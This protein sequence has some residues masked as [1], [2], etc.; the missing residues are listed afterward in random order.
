MSPTSLLAAAADPAAAGPSIGTPLVWAA[1]IGVVALLFVVDFV[2]T[3]RP[4][5]VSM[6]EAVGW[7]AFYVSVPLAF[8]VWVWMLMG[9][10]FVRSALRVIVD[11]LG[12]DARRWRAFEAQCGRRM[13]GAARLSG[14]YDVA[15]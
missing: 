8:G 12:R 9:I 4:H 14:R 10:P 11:G 15:S 1:T 5:E 2:I 3:R 6:R 7:S 13:G